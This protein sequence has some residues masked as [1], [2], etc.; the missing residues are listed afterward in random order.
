MSLFNKNEGSLN[1]NNTL[2]LLVTCSLDESRNSISKKVTSRTVELLQSINLS[3]RLILFD[4]ASSFRDHLKY[5]PKVTAI[6]QSKKN[7]GLWSAINWVLLNYENIFKREFEYL[8]LIESDCLHSNFKKLSE[9]ERFL[10]KNKNFYCVRTQEF[11]VFQRWR[12]D[13]QL[14][15]F[16]FYKKRSAIN[17]SNAINQEKAFF[18]KNKYYS[19]LYVSNLHPKLPALNRISVMRKVFG[20]LSKLSSFSE[21]DYFRESM[22]YNNQIGILNKGIYYSIA[23]GIGTKKVLSGSHSST[24]ELKKIGYLRTRRSQ[25]LNYDEV[26]VTCE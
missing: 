2:F 15:Y 4:N 5:I 9:C 6:C 13:K 12:F 8:Y 11:D 18:E 1:P 3:H 17:L 16:P 7:L 24:K 10:D 21:S 25:I 14:R 19:N 20:S 23:E 22:K 26:L